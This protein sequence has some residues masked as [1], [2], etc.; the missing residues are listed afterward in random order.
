ML[1]HDILQCWWMEMDEVGRRR[2]RRSDT[3]KIY[4]RANAS[5][6]IGLVI[7]NTSSERRLKEDTLGSH[8]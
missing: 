2:S 7:F 3:K 5:G 1:L 6:R 4:H 8:L